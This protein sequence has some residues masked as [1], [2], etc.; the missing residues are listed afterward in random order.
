MSRER[1]TDREGEQGIKE[2]RSG[3]CDPLPRTGGNKYPSA[4]LHSLTN[5]LP[6]THCRS[7]R[8]QV[9]SA[10]RECG[11]LR[12]GAVHAKEHEGA[13]LHGQTRESEDSS[14]R[15]ERERG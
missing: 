4:C 11:R 12:D 3:V 10:L 14:C 2:F 15:R 9:L 8:R 5:T 6:S 7:G 1:E 13:L